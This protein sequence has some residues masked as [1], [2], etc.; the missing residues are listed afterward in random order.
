MDNLLLPYLTATDESERQ[1]HLDELLVVYAT[2]VVRNILRQK[3]GFYVNQV[4]VNP[5]NPD[6]EDLFHEIITKGIELFTV[7]P[8]STSPQIENFQQYVGRIATNTCL[9]YMRAKS[10][11]RTRLKYSLR[12]LLSRRSE[13]VLWKSGDRLFCGLAA[14][15]EKREPITSYRLAEVEAQ[16]PIFRTTEFGSED[17]RKIPLAKVVVE[18]LR[19]ANEPFEIDQLV[20]LT[21]ILLDIKDRPTESLDDEARTYLEERISDKTLMSNPRLDFAKLLRSLWQA[22]EALPEKQRDTF[23]LGFADEH[24][25]DLFTLLFEADIATLSQLAKQLG[26]SPEELTRLWTAMPMDVAAIAVELNGTRTQVWKWRFEALRRL[27]KQLRP[28]LTQK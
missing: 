23:C 4:G 11:A 22:V 21:A 15:D 7:L 9:D 2:P 5:Y 25:E 16:L 26:R 18:L 27:E 17:I 1:E 14:W 13:F 10:P 28:F 8:L 6:A 19:W 24:G 3:L 12:E 20:N